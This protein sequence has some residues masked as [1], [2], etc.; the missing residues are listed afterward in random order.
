MKKA[1]KI[2]ALAMAVACLAFTAQVPLTWTSQALLGALLI[3]MSVVFGRFLPDRNARLVLSFVSVFCTFRYTCWRWKSTFE[4]LNNNGWAVDF[5]GLLFGFLLLGAEAYA[6]CILVLGYFQS[7]RPL[8]RRPIPLP[9]DHEGWPS[10]DI[11]IPTY[12]EPLEVVRPTVLAALGIDWP[13]DK[14][15]VYVLD[16]G[17]RPEFKTFSE[18]CGATYI[19]R[20]D[21]AHAKA[22]NINHALKQTKGEYIAIF[23]CDHIATRS[24]L[25]MTMGWFLKDSRLGMLQTPHHFYSPDPFERNLGVFRKVPNEGSLFYGI[26]QQGSDL[27]NATFFCGSCA[28]LRRTAL[29]EIGGIAVETVTEDAH[30]SL[31]MQRRGWNTAY[32]G[33]PQAAG[34]ATGS[35]AAHIG[36][37]IRWARGM[38]QILRIDC[39]LL[40]R[41]LKLSQRLCYFNS[42]IHYLY[43]I[44]R[45]IFLT[46]PLVYLLFGR[47]NLYG[48]LA[49]ILAYAFPH[50]VIASLANSRIQGNHR[51]SFWNEVYETILAPYILLPTTFAIINPKWGKFN[52]TSKASVLDESF[53]DFKV[54]RPYLFLI[55]LNLVGIGLAIPK[56]LAV[57]DSTGVLRINILWAV[58]NTL[59]LG[60]AV[61]VA[62]ESRQRRATVRIKATVQAQLLLPGNLVKPAQVVDMSEGGLALDLQNAA[63]LSAGESVTVAIQHGQE[64]YDFV[65]EVVEERGQHLRLRFSAS[66]LDHYRA[67]T[68]MVYA[69]AD[70]W[71]RWTEGQEGD[72]ILQSLIKIFSIGLYGLAGLPSK[73]MSRP[74]PE[75][76][77]GAVPEKKGSI[78]RPV[79]ISGLILALLLIPALLLRGAERDGVAAPPTPAGADNSTAFHERHD[80]SFYGLQQAVALAVDGAEASVPIEIAGT[81]AVDRSSI[82]L[83]YRASALSSPVLIEAF[84]NGTSLGTVPVAPG[85]MQSG[86]ATLQIPP[87]LVVRENNLSFRAHCEAPCAETSATLP[88]VDIQPSSELSLSG[89]TLRLPNELSNLPLP[90]VDLSSRR[91][92][93]LSFVFERTPDLKALKAA[94]IVSSWLGV[95]SDYRGIH[96]AVSVGTIPSGNVILFGSPTS[97]LVAGLGIAAHG[98]TVAIRDNPSDP[99]GKILAVVGDTE[100]DLLLG[101]QALALRQFDAS[102]DTTNVSAVK[103]PDAR[104][105]Y[106]SPRWLGTDNPVQIAA[107]ASSSMLRA[108]LGNQAVIYF[109]LAP[110]LYFGSHES[111]PLTISYRVAGLRPN[112]K[113]EMAISLNGEFVA[114]RLLD[115]SQDLT[116]TKVSIP[117]ALLYPAN[118]LRISL[119]NAQAGSLNGLRQAELTISR[120]TTLDLSGLSHN[121]MMPRLDLF[122]ASGYPF[123]RLADLSGTAVVIPPK[124]APA[125]I[126][127]Y[128][129][130]LGFLGAKAGYPGLKF[131]LLSGDSDAVNPGKDLLVIGSDDDQPMYAHFGWRMPLIPAAGHLQPIDASSGLTTGSVP[132]WLGLA[133]S[134]ELFTQG[135][136]DSSARQRRELAE[137]LTGD[138]PPHLVL[139]EFSNSWARSGATTVA[140][141]SS[142]PE[143]DDRVFERLQSAVKRGDIRGNSLVLDGERL[144]SFGLYSDTYHLNSGGIQGSLNYWSSHHLLSITLLVFCCASVLGWY[145]GE[146]LEERAEERLRS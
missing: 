19:I 137:L 113:A 14:L 125:E 49:A 66:D 92:A 13:I 36:Q 34:L 130:A 127:T 76:A 82:L 26:V 47:S 58:L 25:Q 142:L 48:S 65:T 86:S 4:Y 90:F 121:V 117:S 102:G 109:N 73:L 111:L 12:N 51:H 28:V 114:K 20:T 45:L 50:L 128:L 129:D 107:A 103:L 126:S 27:W 136:L 70:S 145:W 5:W 133:R 68:R 112:T 30:T 54:A 93:E 100:E 3:V 135:Q 52:V 94:G 59:L 146:F 46:A 122:A 104:S 9:G 33:I 74:G 60:T 53:F 139:S 55:F 132:P 120:T 62:T 78:A 106:D 95:L 23:D 141:G 7:A 43:A 69:R 72:N 143:L 64:R 18:E 17:R 110:D 98:S 80:L 87:E 35:L 91:P 29:E 22:G 116:S 56:Y 71:I 21:N 144:R 88:S 124:P 97:S 61:A 131:Q 84:L 83:K 32:I 89:L 31:R 37:R 39:P 24:F 77:A 138:N 44:P 81:R 134:W 105:P 85:G 101:A 140:I 16:D 63:G 15:N 11:Y 1:I 41:G 42:V 38:V 8:M 108:T 118:T 99:L 6:A 119:Y 2:F 79:V 123:T 67:V 75:R 57:G 115:T 40:G 96:C 10:V